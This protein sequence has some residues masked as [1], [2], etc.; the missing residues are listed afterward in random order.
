MNIFE[1]L[2]ELLKKTNEEIDYAILELMIQKKKQKWI[3]K[4]KII[5]EFAK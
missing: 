4:L 3:Q 1:L 5:L 2:N